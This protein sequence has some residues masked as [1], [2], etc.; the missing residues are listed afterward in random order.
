M[1]GSRVQDLGDRVMGAGYLGGRVGVLDLGSGS[2][3]LGLGGSLDCCF[4][5][6]DGRFGGTGL[7]LGVRA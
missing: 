6:I 1:A 2:G 4:F 3:L 7:G 5:V